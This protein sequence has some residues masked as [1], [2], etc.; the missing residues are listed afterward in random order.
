MVV[1]GVVL[2]LSVLSRLGRGG[3]CFLCLVKRLLLMRHNS[4]IRDSRDCG[5][6]GGSDCCLG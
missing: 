6:K 4:A 2:L 1:V 3:G 5:S